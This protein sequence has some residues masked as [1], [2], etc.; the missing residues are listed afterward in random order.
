MNDS[1]GPRGGAYVAQHRSVAAEIVERVREETGHPAPRRAGLLLAVGPARTCRGSSPTSTTT[2]AT[3]ARKNAAGV[4]VVPIGFVSDH[5]EV[6]YDLDT[7]AHGDRREARA[8]VRARGDGRGRPAV[9]GDG[10]RPAPGAGGGRARR[11]ARAG[12]RGRLTRV[13]GRVPGRLLPQPARSQAGARRHGGRPMTRLRRRPA[14][15]RARRGGARP[16]RWSSDA[17][18]GRCRVADTK[19]SADRRRHRG[20]PGLRGADPRPAARRAPGRRLP[21]RGGR[22]RRGHSRR[23]LGR[24]PDRRHRQLPLRARRSTR[25]RS[26][27]SSTAEVVAGVVAPAADRHRVTPRTLGGGVDLRRRPAPGARRRTAGTSGW[28]HR[29]Q[30][31]ARGAGEPG[32]LHRC[33]CCRGCATSGARGRAPSTCAPWP[34]GRPTATSRRAPTSGTTPPA[35]WSS[36][37][38]GPDRA[39]SGAPRT[40]ACWRPPRQA[41]SS[42]FLEARCEERRLRRGTPDD[43]GQ[44][45]RRRCS[46]RHIVDGAVLF[47]PDW[48]TIWRRHG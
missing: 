16:R 41:A 19:S 8:A 11:R 9:R 34:P 45:V 22:R 35:G 5:M 28:C 2:C 3:C 7:E 40:C 23:A 6:V 43:R 38:P 26:R 44:R 4:V 42:Q 14:G 32:R 47:G 29:L 36:R 46:A 12:R 24:R 27:P 17:R 48:C 25:S 10:A 37:R 30:L 1:S 18:R 39:S 21:R 31:R 33:A 20:R 15:A 13:V